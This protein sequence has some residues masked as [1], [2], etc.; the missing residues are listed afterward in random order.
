MGEIANSSFQD[1]LGSP[2]FESDK[3]S[4]LFG[5]NW[6]IC[7]WNDFTNMEILFLEQFLHCGGQRVARLHFVQFCGHA[8]LLE[9]ACKGMRLPQGKAVLAVR[10]D[11]HLLEIREEQRDL[12]DL[13]VR[14]KPA[15]DPG[16]RS[17]GSSKRSRRRHSGSLLLDPR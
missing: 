5:G 9:G 11:G 8:F 10:D 2:G 3:I 14:I 7:S 1:S 15:G 13:A 4:Y 12:F 6:K 16:D 17:G